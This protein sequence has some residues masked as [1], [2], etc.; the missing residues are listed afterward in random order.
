MAGRRRAVFLDKDGTLI[1]DVPYN[2]DPRRIRF[3]PGVLDGARRLH[4]A[5]YRLV[6]VTNQ[7][8]VALGFFEAAAL[9]AVEAALRDAFSAAGAPLAGFFYCPHHPSGHV[10]PYAAA[11]GCRKPM[12]GLLHAAARTLDIDL[13][14]SWMVGDILNDVE[15]GRRAGCRTVLERRPHA[16]ARG[17]LVRGGDDR[18]PACGRST[19]HRPALPAGTEGLA[20]LTRP[21]ARRATSSRSGW[22]TSATC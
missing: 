21:G 9:D 17:A 7:P 22:T 19:A 18:D 11:C 1:A 14:G 12:P 15:A 5:G 20:C 8:G 6:V 4:A 10:R 13:A 2:V 16:R 3:L